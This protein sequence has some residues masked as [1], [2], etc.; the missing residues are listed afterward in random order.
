MLS[1]QLSKQSFSVCLLDACFREIELSQ[2]ARKGLWI[3]IVQ[4]V[5]VC[6]RRLP[7]GLSKLNQKKQFILL[8]YHIPAKSLQILPWPFRET[9]SFCPSF[10]IIISVH[11]PYMYP[12]VIW[13]G[14]QKWQ[15]SLKSAQVD[16]PLISKA[17]AL[18][19]PHN[20]RTRLRG[21]EC[22]AYPRSGE[23]DWSASTMPSVSAY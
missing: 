1:L 12:I 5:L 9:P 4:F 22:P 7:F 23:Q 21:Q 11:K 15:I 3:V 14:E 18:R 16:Y 17:H 8:L 20:C 6:F 19:V 10:E 13:F 2:A